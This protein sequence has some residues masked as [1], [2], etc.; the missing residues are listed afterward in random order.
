MQWKSRLGIVLLRGCNL[1]IFFCV[2]LPSSHIYNGLVRLEPHDIYKVMGI[3]VRTFSLMNVTML[4]PSLEVFATLL[5]SLGSRSILPSY[6]PGPMSGTFLWQTVSYWMSIQTHFY[7]RNRG[8]CL[9]YD[10][11][12]KNAEYT[13]WTQKPS[14]ISSSYKIKTYWNAFINMGLQIN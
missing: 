13:G 12:K 8:V 2:N 9:T 5:A 14:L 7:R 4:W 6:S 10:E 3:N 1:I 11:T